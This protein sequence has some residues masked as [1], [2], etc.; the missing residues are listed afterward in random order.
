[1][2]IEM[3]KIG[4]NSNKIDTDNKNLLPFHQTLFFFKNKNKKKS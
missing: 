3:E 1:M 4:L 2:F